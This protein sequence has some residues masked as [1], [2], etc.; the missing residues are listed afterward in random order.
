MFIQFDKGRDPQCNAIARSSIDFRF[1]K[2]KEGRGIL[3]FPEQGKNEP[4]SYL[5]FLFC[6]AFGLRP[7]A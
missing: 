1:Y 7:I 3:V 4:K 6:V 2:K 5:T